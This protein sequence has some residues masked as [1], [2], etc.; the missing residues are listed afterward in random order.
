MVDSRGAAPLVDRRI[1]EAA[2]APGTW[3]DGPPDPAAPTGVLG[4][5]VLA[6]WCG[7]V[8]GGLDGHTGAVLGAVRLWQWCRRPPSER[9]RW[10]VA[11]ADGDLTLAGFPARAVVPGTLPG[12][13]RTDPAPP[14]TLSA[15]FTEL[16]AHRVGAVDPPDGQVR[17]LW[18][19]WLAATDPG[20]LTRPPEV[21]L[22]PGTGR[23]SLVLWVPARPGRVVVPLDAVPCRDPR[24]LVPVVS[25]VT[26]DPCWD[27]PGPL[28]LWNH[29][30]RWAAATLTVNPEA[31]LWLRRAA[32]APTP[33]G[34]PLPAAVALIL[35]GW[36]G[37]PVRTAPVPVGALAAPAVWWRW[38]LGTLVR[39]PDRDR[40]WVLVR[41]E[42]RWVEM[43]GH[44]GV[45]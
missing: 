9:S 24:P 32:T 13:L 37:P 2:A 21:R 33:A 42:R 41:M 8:P 6:G 28:I 44:L 4:A 1:W 45:R 29:Y 26:V 17:R 18:A 38:W 23:G 11:P 22:D 5:W 15:G 19:L 7:P 3:R 40:P 14:S 31:R 16:A 25:A 43:L 12:W 27:G 10:V 35:A 36:R 34:L 39:V 30:A 20:R